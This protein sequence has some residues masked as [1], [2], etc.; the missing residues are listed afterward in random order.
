MNKNLLKFALTIFLFSNISAMESSQK[1]E[2]IKNKTFELTEDFT[3]AEPW[4]VTGICMIY[5]NY[6]NILADGENKIK[7]PEDACLILFEPGEKIEIDG[8]YIKGELDKETKKETYKI[9]GITV[10][11]PI[12]YATLSEISKLLKKI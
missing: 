11:Q 3:P 12:H 6:N 7:V 1:Q 10:I 9:K 2:I 5:C 8:K 4:H